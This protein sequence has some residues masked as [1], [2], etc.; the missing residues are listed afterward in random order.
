MAKFIVVSIISIQFVTLL[1]IM[2]A[3]IGAVL[4]A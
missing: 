3:I 2:G 1:G 4:G